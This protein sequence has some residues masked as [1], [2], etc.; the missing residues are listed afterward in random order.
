MSKKVIVLKISLFLAMLAV[1]ITL[2]IGDYDFPTYASGGLLGVCLFVLLFPFMYII[3]SAEGRRAKRAFLVQWF[4]TLLN[5]KESSHN[6]KISTLKK[7][8]KRK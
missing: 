2:V 8:G 4:Y 7:S 5:I 1:S 6:D 3:V